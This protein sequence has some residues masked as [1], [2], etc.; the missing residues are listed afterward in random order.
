MCPLTQTRLLLVLFLFWVDVA[1]GQLLR[2]RE[3]RMGASETR[4]IVIAVRIR[5]VEGPSADYISNVY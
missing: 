2:M 1:L 3:Y 4:V 5:T